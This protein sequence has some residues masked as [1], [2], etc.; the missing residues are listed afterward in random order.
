MT[1]LEN[2]TAVGLISSTS[3]KP[4]YRTTEG[5]LSLLA[6]ICSCLVA[7]KA[8]PVNVSTAV[9][10]DAVKALPVIAVG[11]AIARS[12]AKVGWRQTLPLIESDLGI[13][14]ASSTTTVTFPAVVPSGE[15]VALTADPTAPADTTDPAPAVSP[16]PS[17]PAPVAPTEPPAD[18]VP[19][20]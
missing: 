13:P 11:Y 17:E 10:A 18:D 16:A 3:P 19:P 6:F 1:D 4:G 7:T 12:I 2:A 8:V 15:P 20:L 14:T 9:Q 5:W